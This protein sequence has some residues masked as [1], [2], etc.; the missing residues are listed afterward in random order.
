MTAQGDILIRWIHQFRNRYKLSFSH[1]TR[2]RGSG[3]S[4]GMANLKFKKVEDVVQQSNSMRERER[5]LISQRYRMEQ[6]LAAMRSR[7]LPPLPGTERRHLHTF[8][9]DEHQAA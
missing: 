5:R 3:V 4:I 6:L 8:A 2:R 1:P 9:E 7:L